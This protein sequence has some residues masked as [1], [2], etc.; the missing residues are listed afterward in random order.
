MT[1]K[2]L[3]LV[4]MFVLVGVLLITWQFRRGKTPA[5]PSVANAP[6]AVL[7][8]TQA[9]AIATVPAGPIADAAIAN[10]ATW[11][12]TFSPATDTAAVLDDG[13]RLAAARQPARL[14]LM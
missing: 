12:A 9:V 10:F 6:V 3:P 4:V 5:A 11:L 13:R 14:K 2:R 1:P 8:P 7:P